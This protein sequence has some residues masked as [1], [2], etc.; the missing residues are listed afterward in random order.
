ML[1]ELKEY[2]ILVYNLLA[3][4][5]V[6]FPEPERMVLQIPQSVLAATKEK[7]LTEYLE[8]VFCERC[9]LSLKVEPL[10]M[11]TKESKSR[12][13]SE[14]RIQQEAAHI[15]AQS[16]FG[17]KAGESYPEEELH[18]EAL[19]QKSMEKEKPVPEKKKRCSCTGKK[20][21]QDFREG[22]GGR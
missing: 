12:K 22:R 19:P 18:E 11:E 4:A 2:S 7:E 20:H 15:I 5:K 21:V 3:T 9:G 16:S 17:N 10:Y 14:L 8:K 13:N 1:T 6:E